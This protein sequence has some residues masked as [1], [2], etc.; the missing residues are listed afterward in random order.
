MTVITIAVDFKI[1]D[2]DMV[3]RIIEGSCISL[4]AQVFVCG[5]AWR[6]VYRQVIEYQADERAGVAQLRWRVSGR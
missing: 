4:T 5:D 2:I 3:P 6:K 1:R